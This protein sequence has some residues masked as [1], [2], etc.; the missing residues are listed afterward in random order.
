MSQAVD[1]DHPRA[2]DFLRADCSHCNDFFR[3]NGVA[4]LTNKELFDFAVDPTITEDNVD[5]VL[6]RMKERAGD[7]PIERTAEEQVRG[8]ATCAYL[9]VFG[10]ALGHP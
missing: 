10:R 9:R 3:R 1:L 6:E 7:R 5:A 8:E 2:L 4:V